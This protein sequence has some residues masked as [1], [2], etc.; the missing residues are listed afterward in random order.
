[1]ATATY[2]SGTATVDDLEG[3]HERP[4]MVSDVGNATPDLVISRAFLTC[5]TGDLPSDAAEGDSLSVDG[6]DYIVRVLLHDGTGL[7]KIELEAEA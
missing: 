4:M 7:T 6:R 1:M 5:R 3:L 2:I